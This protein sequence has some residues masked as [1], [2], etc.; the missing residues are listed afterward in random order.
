MED[1]KSHCNSN[2]STILCAA[3]CGSGKTYICDNTSIKSIEVEYWKY[4]E[5]GLYLEYVEDIKSY[6][7]KVDYI[8]ISTEPDG[9]KL[10][11]SAGFD[12]TL[13][14]P[15]NE[16]R[17]EYLDRY[18]QRDSP[19]DFIGPFMKYWDIWID[20]LKK[21]DYCKHIVLESGQYLYDII[22]TN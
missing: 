6:I 2:S 4:K 14:Y 8:F 11:Y 22:K 5:K 20:E 13:I 10:L 3:F 9:M 21:Q 15:R 16:L 7:G 1:L 17:N 18:L 19:C 12:I